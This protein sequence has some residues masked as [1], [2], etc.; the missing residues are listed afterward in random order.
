MYFHSFF[1]C[2]RLDKVG[3]LGD[4]PKWTCDIDRVGGQAVR[5]KQA[6]PDAPHKH[7]L[8]YSIGSNGDYQWEDAVQETLSSAGGCEIHIFDPG[9]FDRGVNNTSKGMMYHKWGLT[10]S[11]EKTANDLVTKRGNGIVTHSFP[12]IQKLLGH[13]GRTI[14]ILKIDCEGCEWYVMLAWLNQY[15]LRSAI[16]GRAHSFHLYSFFLLHSLALSQCNATAFSR[17]TYKDWVNTD[18]RQILIETHDIPRVSESTVTQ[19]GTYPAMKASDYFDAFKQAGFVLF[20]KEVNSA[21]GEGKCVEW[22]YL[23]LHT[24]FL[25]DSIARTT[26]H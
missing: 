7:C 18:I 19:W 4:G 25:G 23:K 16:E 22:S 13:E 1:T 8:I 20:S 14:D 9:N 11:Y 26:N 3:G 10:S 21:W 2:P 6:D 12:E 24:D 15:V 5:R 17:T